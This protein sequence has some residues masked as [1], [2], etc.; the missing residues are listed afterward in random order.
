[1]GSSAREVALAS[2]LTEIAA[3]K[4]S[5]AARLALAWVLARDEQVVPL[6]DPRRPGELADALGAQTVRLSRDDL[7][8]MES[9]VADGAASEPVAAL[10]LAKSRREKPHAIG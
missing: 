1:L 10:Y 6:I 3:E 8:R 5:T 9:A 7:R 4:D 2:V